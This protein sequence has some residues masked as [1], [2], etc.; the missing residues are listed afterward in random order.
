MEEYHNG[1]DIAAD[2]GSNVYAV[3]TGTVTDIH[4]SET[5]G[6]VLS[7]ETDDGYKIVY[8]HL[9]SINVEVDEPIVQGEVVAYVG[10][11]GLSTGP[12]LH[13]TVYLDTMLMDPIQFTTYN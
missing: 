13:Y 9:N 6:N 4:Y 3:R 1:I 10:T 12:H 2:K 5:Y 11:T 8:A 7:Y